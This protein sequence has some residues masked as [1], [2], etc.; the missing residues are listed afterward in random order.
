M[1]WKS[2]IRRQESKLGDISQLGNDDF[3][4]SKAG[5]SESG[6]KYWWIQEKEL[7][8][9]DTDWIRGT[10]HEEEWR[11]LPGLWFG[12][13]Y[14]VVPSTKRE[15][16]KKNGC[17]ELVERE[18]DEFSFPHVE[19][20]ELV[21]HP[22]CVVGSWMSG[23][24]ILKRDISWSTDLGLYYI[25]MEVDEFVQGNNEHWRAWQKERGA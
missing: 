6:E 18:D 7:T 17:R 1:G 10:S 11:W 14:T 3:Y 23:S 4:L 16:R 13:W 9:P 25:D 2:S 21:G 15:L 5:G 8:V 22:R 24:E 20:E 19:F 12:Q